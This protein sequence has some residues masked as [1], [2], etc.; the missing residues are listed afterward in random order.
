MTTGDWCAKGARLMRSP[1]SLSGIDLQQE[2]LLHELAP[3][4]QRLLLLSGLPLPGWFYMVLD[5]LFT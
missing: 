3:E 1:Y 4:M 5:A 2:V